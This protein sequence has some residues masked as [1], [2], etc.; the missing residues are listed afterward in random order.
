MGVATRTALA[1]ARRPPIQAT[2]GWL[3]EGPAS[4]SGRGWSRRSTRVAAWPSCSSRRFA[5]CA[6]MRLLLSLLRLVE[7]M[8]IMG[9]LPLSL[10]G[11]HRCCLG[12]VEA[13]PKR[14]CA[15]LK[16]AEGDDAGA[17]PGKQR[18]RDHHLL[19]LLGRGHPRDEDEPG[20]GQEGS[21][22]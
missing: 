10:G 15:A 8:R 19:Q 18:Q 9:G 21:P 17:G 16:S 13:A 20:G 7:M 3:Y 12:P 11:L 6:R 14:R 4:Q 1:S 22:G 5:S 2:L